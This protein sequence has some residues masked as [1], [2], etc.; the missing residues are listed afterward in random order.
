MIEP[1]EVLVPAP[2]VAYRRIDE[3]IVLVSPSDNSLITL[4]ES[5]S[6]VWEAL[7]GRTVGAVAAEIERVFDVGSKQAL[8]DVRG[9]LENFLN[10]GLVIRRPR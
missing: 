8:E 3:Q 2:N 5:G 6:A 7:D 4:N 1:D 10:R 9:F